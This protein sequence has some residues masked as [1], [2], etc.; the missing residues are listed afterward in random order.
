M[1]DLGGELL[2]AARQQRQGREIRRVPVALDHLAGGRRR[3]EP[4]LLTDM[5]FNVRRQVRERAPGARHFAAR[6]P[7]T[8]GSKPLAMALRLVVPDRQ[9][10]AERDGL[11]MDTMRTSDHEG[12][13]VLP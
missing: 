8:R 7:V 3:L 1:P 4:Q 13:T 5:G 12:V 11:A 9:L 10:D 2:D 6:D